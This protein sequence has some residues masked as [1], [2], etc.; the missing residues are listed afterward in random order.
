[1]EDTKKHPDA[2]TYTNDEVLGAEDKHVTKTPPPS[3]LLHKIVRSLS[4]SKNIIIL[5]LSGIF[6]TL[7]FADVVV[8]LLPRNNELSITDT[9][10]PLPKQQAKVPSAP[11]PTISYKLTPSITPKAT[12]TP[13]PSPTRQPTATPTRTPTPTIQPTATPTPKP[14]TFTDNSYGVLESATCQGITG[15][16]YD[17]ANPTAET[18]IWLYADGGTYGGIMSGNINTT[19]LRADINTNK[20]ITGTHGFS[21]TVI[22]PLK[23]G[24]EHSLYAYVDIN[25]VRYQLGNTPLYLTCTQ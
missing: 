3:S 25:G 4:I 5:V 8:F 2:V 24:K 7:V 14:A 16:A 6:V 15:W 20:N 1:M 18:N 13:S 9:S 22:A 19:I 17:P 21:F 11:S 12:S 10:T 23:D